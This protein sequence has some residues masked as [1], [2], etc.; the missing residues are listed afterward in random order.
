[1]EVKNATT[2]KVA[3]KKEP[4]SSEPPSIDFS[5]R[6]AIRWLGWAGIW[7]FLAVF[8][9]AIAR[10][11]FPRLLFEPPTKFKVGFP[12]EYPV[13]AISERYKDQYRLWIV[14]ERHKIFV[15]EAKCTHLG[16][17]PNWL[18]SEG[19]FKCPCHGSGF[20]REGV[21]V[22]GPAPRPLPRFKVSLAEDGQILVDKGITFRGERN[23]WGK[24]GAYVDV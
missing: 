3:A 17:T 9:I 15:I 18:E 24:P 16:C 4:F 6:R 20:N 19:K 5:R 2:E 23:E 12:N 10:F 13:G 7:S 11:F 1:M 21:N 22:E 14:R 8:G